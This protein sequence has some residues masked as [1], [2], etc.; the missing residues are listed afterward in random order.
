MIDSVEQ[1][2]WLDYLNSV[3]YTA[4]ECKGFEDAKLAIL[5]LMLNKSH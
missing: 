5:Q 3:G 4:I 1:K 2:D